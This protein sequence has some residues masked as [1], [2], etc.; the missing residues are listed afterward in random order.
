MIKKPTRPLGSAC[1]MQFLRQPFSVEQS[2]DDSCELSPAAGSTLYV[3][4]GAHFAA[5]PFGHVHAVK[6][7]CRGQADVRMTDQSRERMAA[8]GR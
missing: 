2:R 7:R 6:V 5:R 1:E 4:A 3:P 8:D